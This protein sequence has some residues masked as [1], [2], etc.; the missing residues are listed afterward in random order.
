MQA[1]EA[2]LRP[3]L[4][5][6]LG[7]TLTRQTAMNFDAGG[8]IGI[9]IIYVSPSAFTQGV[10]AKLQ[11]IVTSFGGTRQ[12]GGSFESGNAAT[13]FFTGA[14]IDGK[15]VQGSLSAVNNNIGVILNVRQ[16]ATP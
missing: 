13:V 16:A 7:V 2:A 12:A 1:I 3:V 8:T 11:E 10:G 14:T 15:A 6:K 4:E 9:N 5:S